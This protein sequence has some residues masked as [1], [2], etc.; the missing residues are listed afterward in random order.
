MFY[1]IFNTNDFSRVSGVYRDKSN[2]QADCE[3]MNLMGR[4]YRV[5]EVD[6]TGEA[7]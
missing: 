6:A 4:I 1:A 2:A 7:Y 3:R 5:V